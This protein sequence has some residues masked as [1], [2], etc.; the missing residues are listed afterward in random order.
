MD[1]LQV[2]IGALVQDVRKVFEREQPQDAIKPEGIVLIGGVAYREEVLFAFKE[3][4]YFTEQNI[5]I[6]CVDSPFTK[7]NKFYHIDLDYFLLNK[8]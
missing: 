6:E 3:C 8:L 7:K 4:R 1:N 5:S 2:I